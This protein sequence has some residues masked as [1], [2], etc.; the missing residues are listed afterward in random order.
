MTVRTINEVFRDFEIDGMPSSGPHK[1]M[2]A[3]IRDTLN[4]EL[5]KGTSVAT[6]TA[7][8]ALDTSKATAAYLTE[9]GREGWFTW[10]AGNYAARVTADTREA[11][12]IKADAIA[13]TAGAWVRV[14]NG[15]LMFEWFGAVGDDVADDT[16]AL[17]A[18]ITF[19]QTLILDPA[20]HGRSGAKYRTTATLQVPV[21]YD[22]SVTLI[23]N[24]ATLHADHANNLIFAGQAANTT[25]AP[26]FT[27]KGWRV[28][29]TKGLYLKFWGNALIEENNF[30]AMSRGIELEESY[31]VTIRRNRFLS[32][33]AG[34]KGVYCATS[35]MHLLLANNGFYNVENCVQFN[36]V[37]YNINIIENDMEGGI[38][39]I[40]V[41][42][43]GGG[44]RIEGNYIE[45]MTGLPVFF[46]ASMTGLL[47][48]GNW[49]GYNSGTQQW[50]NV[51][52]GELNGN[53]FANQVQSIA[54]SASGLTIG[55]NVFASGSNIIYSPYVAPTLLNSFTNTG[56][57]WETAGYR[58]D[59]DG[60]VRLKGMIQAAADNVAFTLPVDFRP[61]AQKIFPIVG[62][63]GAHGSVIVAA[64]GNVTCFRSSDTTL[65]LATVVFP[66]GA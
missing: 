58:K 49:L 50:L 15:I 21:V 42:A 11:V 61:A 24:G 27:F 34:G 19:A 12:F 7:L 30:V 32:F 28:R 16:A 65:S 37:T 47:F 60:T 55:N 23:G 10:H 18:C 5:S 66:A 64:S 3:D 62:S 53:I 59:A 29:G 25:G 38:T 63:T 20:I 14:H 48:A 6:R 13:T 1:P 56:G 9:A 57:A 45:A 8:K 4:A 52:S 44:F 36:A 54:A 51:A 31:S 39:A 35:A 33:V 17:Q 26:P 22:V 43:G 2:K 46:G 40:S 41:P